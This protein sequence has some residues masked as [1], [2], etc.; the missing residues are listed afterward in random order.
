MSFQPEPDH[1][2]SDWYCELEEATAVEDFSAARWRF[3]VNK[4]SNSSASVSEGDQP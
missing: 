1:S 4:R 3:N 2:L